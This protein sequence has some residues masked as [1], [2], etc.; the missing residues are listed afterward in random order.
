MPKSFD[1][2]ARKANSGYAGY[3]IRTIHPGGHKNQYM[4]VCMK[5]NGTW[6]AGEKHRRMK[7]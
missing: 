4:H 3:K 7:K 2:C 5:P 6:A 1:S